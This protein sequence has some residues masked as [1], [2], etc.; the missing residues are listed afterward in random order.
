MMF[1]TEQS[2]LNLNRRCSF[3]LSA[4]P[5][6]RIGGGYSCRTKITLIQEQGCRLIV[7][8]RLVNEKIRFVLKLMND[9][10]DVDMTKKQRT[11]R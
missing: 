9:E 11:H 8:L 4:T 6:A 5:L 10:N 1:K 2:F 7:H 3:W